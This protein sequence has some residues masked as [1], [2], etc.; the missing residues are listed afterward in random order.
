MASSLQYS[1]RVSVDDTYRS[2][3]T[4]FAAQCVISAGSE[5]LPFF[6]SDLS[7]ENKL[8]DA[9][10]FDPVTHADRAVERK[11]RDQ[12]KA[13]YPSHGIYG[14]E[15]GHESGNGLTW[16]ID[17]I[18]GTRAF[19]AGFVHWGVL[20]ALFDGEEPIV[21][22]M[23]Q[24]YVGELFL[25]DGRNAWHQR[26]SERRSIRTSQCERISDAVM[27]TTGVD[28]FP[29]Q[30][31][32]GFE[33]LRKQAKLTRLG[34]DC[35]VHALVAMGGVDIGTDALLQAYDIQAL[36][37]IVRGAGGVVSDYQGG[38][39]SLGGTVVCCAN[40]TLHKEVLRVIEQTG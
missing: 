28:W 35:Y 14:E 17:P 22:A 31:R 25:G 21:G 39:A 8:A 15:F 2:E 16:V 38:D 26:G 4:E 40:E 6:R 18:D 34:G 29:D 27:G 37:P 32:R 33:A 12:L 9:G 24:P 7:V 1:A 20:L 5:A 23:Y 11:I 13:S 30:E 36:I 10:G 19:M 3:L